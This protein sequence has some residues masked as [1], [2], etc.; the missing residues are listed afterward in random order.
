MVRGIVRHYG[1]V[2]E[3][4]TITYDAYNKLEEVLF[5][6]KWFKVNLQGPNRTVVDDDCGFTRLK[7]APSSI[8]NPN[9]R[10]TD[11]FAFPHHLE[12]AFYLPYPQDPEEWSI[13]I[14]FI[15]RAR[16]IMRPEPDV[17]VVG[18]PNQQEDT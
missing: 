3:I 9:W 10:T 16:S 14:P 12:Q 1:K 7:T 11:P 8:Q 5:K 17:V 13:V 6:C 2:E 15:P 4:L 18:N